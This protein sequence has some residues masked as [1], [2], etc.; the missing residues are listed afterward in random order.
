MLDLARIQSVAQSY[1]PQELFAALVWQRQFNEFNGEEVITDL[2]NQP[3]LW[4]SF[5]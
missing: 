5:L 1:S 2:A 4:K 3:N